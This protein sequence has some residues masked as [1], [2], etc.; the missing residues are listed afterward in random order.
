MEE[1]IFDRNVLKILLGHDW[2]LGVMFLCGNDT[3]GKLHSHDFFELVII[4]GGTGHYKSDSICQLRT[5]DVFLVIPGDKHLFT[6]QHQLELINILWVPNE[7]N[8]NFR[9]LSEDPGFVA[10]F[11][12]EPQSRKRDRGGRLNLTHDE[13]KQVIEL[14]QKIRNELKYKQSG[15]FLVA[16][17]LLGQLFAMLCRIYAGKTTSPHRELLMIEKVMNF[18]HEHYPEKIKREE[19]ARLANMSEPTFFRWFRETTDQSPSDYLLQYRLICA[20]ELL[21]TSRMTLSEIA[22][23]TGFSDSNYLGLQ[24]KKKF[25]LTPHKYRM[26]FMANKKT[27]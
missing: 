11:Q 20:E 10:F 7:L 16:T 27:V 4:T 26:A 14:A 24:F 8:F 6:D 9:D 21:R 18:I 5:G 13:L 23:K 25:N 1:V 17:S 3:Q 2:P 12:L 22:L 15:C 19:L